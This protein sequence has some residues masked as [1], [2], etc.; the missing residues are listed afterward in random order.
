[1]LVVVVS[2]DTDLPFTAGRLGDQAC[3]A[4]SGPCGPCAGHRFLPMLAQGS[5][6]ASAQ[7]TEPVSGHG[8]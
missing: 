2:S 8:S 3:V 7:Q 4:S 1:M 6:L 5:G